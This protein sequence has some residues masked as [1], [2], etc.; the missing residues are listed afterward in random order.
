M[1]KDH[2]EGGIKMKRSMLTEQ[3]RFLKSYS[4]L[5]NFL[6]LAVRM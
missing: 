6:F 3:G 5:K 4:T 1:E 2:Y